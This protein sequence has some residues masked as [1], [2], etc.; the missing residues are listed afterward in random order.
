MDL[1]LDSV[2]NFLYKNEYFQSFLTLEQESKHNYNS[3]PQDLNYLY[4]LTT[5]GDFENL[6]NLFLPISS[7]YTENYKEIF[8]SIKTQEILEKVNTCSYEVENIV[9]EFEALLGKC[10]QNYIESLIRAINACDLKEFDNWTLWS[11]RIKCWEKIEK[12]IGSTETLE[13]SDK[14]KR[15]SLDSSLELSGDLDDEVVYDCNEE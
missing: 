12:I 5:A 7:K 4:S 9:K 15:K 10:E 1:T 11:G 8:V 2:L 13:S 14:N 3:Y 6:Y